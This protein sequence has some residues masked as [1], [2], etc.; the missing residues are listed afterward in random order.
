MTATAALPRGALAGAA[1]AG[2]DAGLAAL[3]AALLAAHARDDRTALI[4]LYAEA[5]K[6]SA[7]A[8][9]AF[10]LTHAYVFALEAG[11][12]RAKVLKDRLVEIG[13]DLPDPA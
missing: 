2:R 9:A 1:L 8:A 10:Y 7:A 13:A 11:D 6:I 5:A 3:D 4:G 12:P